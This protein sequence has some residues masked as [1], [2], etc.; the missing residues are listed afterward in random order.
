M[1][2]LIRVIKYSGVI[3]GFLG[4]Y[5]WPVKF[6]LYGPFLGITQFDPK[7]PVEGLPGSVMSRVLL[8]GNQVC[9]LLR[10][11]KTKGGDPVAKKK[12]KKPKK[13]KKIRTKE[14][15]GNGT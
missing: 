12:T 1:G 8:S 10:F 2:K 7:I 15:G 11:L 3:P 5:R 6:D 4:N 14:N 13:G 9:A